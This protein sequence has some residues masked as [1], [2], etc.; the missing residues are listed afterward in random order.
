MR[1]LKRLGKSLAI[2]VGVTDWFNWF[3]L[4]GYV[5]FGVVGGMVWSELAKAVRG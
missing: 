4:A 3:L 2:V 5:F 1:A